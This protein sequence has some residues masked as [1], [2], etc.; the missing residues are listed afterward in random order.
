MRTNSLFWKVVAVLAVLAGFYVGHGLHQP[1]ITSFP[2]E[3]VAKGIEIDPTYS[4]WLS[5]ERPIAITASADG[6][7]LYFWD[8][9]EK[10]QVNSPSA[11]LEIKATV[12]SERQP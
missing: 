6:T 4:P 5:G 9:G 10:T 1:T 2:G 12:E 11:A 7:V 3:S 8:K